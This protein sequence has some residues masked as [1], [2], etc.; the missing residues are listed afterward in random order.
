MDMEGVWLVIC[1]LPS[2]PTGKEFALQCKLEVYCS[3][4]SRSCKD[5]VSETLLK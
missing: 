1:A 5:W 4:S 3:T 2:G